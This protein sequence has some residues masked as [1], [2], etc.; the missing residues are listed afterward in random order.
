MRSLLITLLGGWIAGTLILAGVATQ[1]FRTIDRLLSVPTPEFS[2]AIAP[3]G[4]DEA[5]IVLRYLSSEL[6][7]LY[8][9]AWGFIQLVLGV[10]ILAGALGHRPL[11]RKGVI[12]AAA[13]FV[14]E[15]GRAHV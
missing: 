9:G 5:R 4:H 1:N 11:D 7:R 15:I 10:T 6:N 13:I 12:G 14:I 3:L 8:F 2:R